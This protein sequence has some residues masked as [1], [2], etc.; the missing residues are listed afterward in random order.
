MERTKSE[1]AEAKTR[2]EHDEGV[3]ALRHR[4]DDHMAQA[5]TERAARS[6]ETARRL[7]EHRQAEE[8]GRK[9]RARDS[10][11]VHGGTEAEF[12][13][14]WPEIRKQMLVGRVVND[15]FRGRNDHYK[16]SL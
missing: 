2:I 7:E 5:E 3:K 11:L 13:E 12:E 4:Y 14:A 1:K 6:A 10:F 8:A 9:R 16:P 15:M